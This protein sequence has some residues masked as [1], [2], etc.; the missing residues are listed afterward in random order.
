[1]TEPGECVICGRYQDESHK[2]VETIG[3]MPKAANLE[4]QVPLLIPSI[5]TRIK[6]TAASATSTVSVA[7]P[8]KFLEK[9]TMI[10]DLHIKKSADYG[11]G[12]DEYANLRAS[13][14][15]GV[16]AWLGAIIRLNDKITRIKSLVANGKVE[17][18]AIED[19]FQDIAVYALCAAVLYDET[20]NA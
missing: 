1:M 2:H 7:T 8:D 19:S 20:K 15:F 17:N 14:G 12:E 16:P 3:F 13:E 9:L 4:Y 18:E 10:R 5:F 6:E 11:F